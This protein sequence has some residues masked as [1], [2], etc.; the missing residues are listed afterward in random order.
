MPSKIGYGPKAA[1]KLGIP[2]KEVKKMKRKK[3][4]MSKYASSYKGHKGESE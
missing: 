1:K 2:L 3:G 4:N